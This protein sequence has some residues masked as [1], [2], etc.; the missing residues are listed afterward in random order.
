MDTVQSYCSTSG[1]IASRPMPSLRL[2]SS[3]LQLDVAFEYIC[4][5]KRCRQKLIFGVSYTDRCALYKTRQ[6]RGMRRFTDL[7]NKTAVQVFSIV[8]V[9]V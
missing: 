2:A 5:S 6:V 8:R 9:W 7:K 3:Q 1:T 4:R